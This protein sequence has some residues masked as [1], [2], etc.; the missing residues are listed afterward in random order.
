MSNL[1]IRQRLLIVTII[2]IIGFLYLSFNIINNLNNEKKSLLKVDQYLEYIM[3]SSE[4]IHQLQ[5]ERGLNSGFIESNGKKFNLQIPKQRKKSHKAYLKVKNFIVSQEIENKEKILDALKAFST[6]EIKNYRLQIDALKTTS[7]ENIMLYSA[8]ISK[9]IRTISFFD[10]LNKSKVLTQYGLSYINLLL[11]KENAGQERAVINSVIASKKLLTSDIKNIIR[12]STSQTNHINSFKSL[13]TK[14]L[15]KYYSLTLN[16]EN[17]KQVKKMRE[18]I[19]SSYEKNN[20]ISQM[21]SISGY[22][23]LIHNF[24][25][26]LLRRD[27]KYKN[28]FLNNYKSLQ[29]CFKLY[30]QLPQSEQE[31]KL[32]NQIKYTFTLYKTNIEKISSLQLKNKTASTIDKL[33]KIND[34]NAL[35]AF[36]LLSNNIIGLDVYKWF[37]I[38]T[39]RIDA[40]NNVENK[41]FAQLLNE[42]TLNKK[43]IFNNILFQITYISTFLILII[44]LSTIIYKNITA[45]IQRFQNGLLSFFQFINKEKNTFELLDQKSNNEFGQMSKVLNKG[46]T[47][48]AEHIKLE[49]SQA[50]QQEKRLFEANKLNSLGELIENISHQWRQ[51]LSVISTG[52][53][54]MKMQ[55]EYGVL[56]DDEFY[57]NCDIINK[58]VQNLSKT[59]TSFQHFIEKDNQ[60]SIFNIRKNI[61]DFL[62]LVDGSIKEH[63]INIFININDKI[64]I[65]NYSNEFMQSLLNIFNN[66]KDAFIQ[67]HI[68]DKYIFLRVEEK[69][70]TIILNIKDNAGGIDL[71]ILNKIFEPYST[72]KHKSQGTGLG[73]HMTY[74]LIVDGMKGKIEAR[75]VEFAFNNSSYIGAEFIITLPIS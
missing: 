31:K 58:N 59:I 22:G 4:F 7:A 66:T 6:E 20:L 42:I 14:Q 49:V 18:L 28:L 35:N 17:S 15:I 56:N 39:T 73:L 60:K 63:D 64:E 1:T 30:A 41:I 26:Y 36:H 51:P 24:K 53:T 44:F 48:I 65:N 46:I 61:D 69:N 75:N 38:S 71:S 11:A 74:K 12:L 21:K 8:H 29:R 32:L 16:N 47:T 70:D 55:K 2:P 5:I 50:T 37:K 54:G 72:T 45:Q 34:K 3:Y 68:Q 19:L 40:L 27:I 23:G 43:E 9:I 13:S 25:N 67:N 33:I 52:V 57:K 10:T 62:N